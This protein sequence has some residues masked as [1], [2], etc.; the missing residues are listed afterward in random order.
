[1]MNFTGVLQGDSEVMAKIAAAR[2]A[3]KP[4]DGHEVAYR[5]RLLCDMAARTGCTMKAPFITMAFLCLP[6]IPELKITDKHLWD[7]KNMKVIL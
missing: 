1:M 3:G 6:V 4:V 5:C 2:T 7:S